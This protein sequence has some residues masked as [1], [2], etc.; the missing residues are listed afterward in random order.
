MLR[1]LGREKEIEV[2]SSMLKGFLEARAAG[3]KNYNVLIYEGPIGYGKSRLLAEVVYRTA[4]DGVRVIS[5][6]LAKTDIKQ[7][8]Y[9]LQTLLAIIMSVQNCKSYAKRER[10]LLSKILDPKMRQNLCLLSD[11]LLV[12]VGGISER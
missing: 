8:N 4:K 12:K 9:A 11:I 7:C 5:F 1:S 3:H 2:Y 6:E 10:F